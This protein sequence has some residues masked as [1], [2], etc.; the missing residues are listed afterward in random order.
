M[1]LFVDLR[2]DK[3]I[4]VIFDFIIFLG[5]IYQLLFVILVRF[6][7]QKVMAHSRRQFNRWELALGPTNIQFIIIWHP[8]DIIEAKILLFLPAA[9]ILFIDFEPCFERCVHEEP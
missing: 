5:L 4:I 7:L 1:I 3:T 8:F 6:F 2:G 9:L